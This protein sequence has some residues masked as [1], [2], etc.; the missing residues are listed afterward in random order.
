M[1]LLKQVHLLVGL[2]MVLGSM[3][4]TLT[5]AFTGPDGRRVSDSSG[6]AVQVVLRQATLN[7]TCGTLTLEEVS[8]ILIVTVL[9]HV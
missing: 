8:L 4:H 7:A 9:L 1:L 5:L 2:T 3:G 6:K